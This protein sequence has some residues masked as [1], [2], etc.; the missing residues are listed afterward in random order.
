MA[1]TEPV[2]INGLINLLRQ[3]AVPLFRTDFRD[4]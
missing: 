4:D 2:D 3:D 1:H